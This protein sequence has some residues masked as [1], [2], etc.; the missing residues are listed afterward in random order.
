M[1][2]MK[3]KKDKIMNIYKTPTGNKKSSAEALLFLLFY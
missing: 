2:Q 3:T 1:T